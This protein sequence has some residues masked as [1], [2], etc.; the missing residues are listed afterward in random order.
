[1]TWS[2]CLEPHQEKRM[3]KRWLFSKC[4]HK[5]DDSSLLGQ[6]SLDKECGGK[7]QGRKEG[8]EA[9]DSIPD[10]LPFI[11]TL[12]SLK[13][14]SF[15]HQKRFVPLLSYKPKE[16]R[17]WGLSLGPGTEYRWYHGQLFDC[18]CLDEY[19]TN[20]LGDTEAHLLWGTGLDALGANAS[21]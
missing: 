7:E 18:C 10:S 17:R 20:T 9:K 8:W 3:S 19:S 15:Y 11:P 14:P 13:S 16:V 6:R 21:L 2:T 1:M 5:G 12:L 4:D